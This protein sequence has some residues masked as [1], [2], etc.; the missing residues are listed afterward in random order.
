MLSFH[1][2]KSDIF[3]LFGASQLGRS[4]CRAV[5]WNFF[6]TPKVGPTSKLHLKSKGALEKET[7]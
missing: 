7:V 1:G 5:A 4:V 3:I 6:G 2:E